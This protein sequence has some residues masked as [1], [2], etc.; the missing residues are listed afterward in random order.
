MDAAIKVG[1]QP[2]LTT[3]RLLLR[4]YAAGDLDA[5][6][7][8]FGDPDVTAFTFLGYR[9]REQTAEVL[10]EYMGFLAAHGYGMLA[11]LDRATGE[12]LG[13]AGLFMS[14]MGVPALRYALVKA[15]WGRGYAVEASAAVIDDSFER[16]GLERLIAGVKFENTPSLRVMEKLGFA[17]EETMTAEGHTFGLFSISRE[18][19]RSRKG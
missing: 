16:L 4:P 12:Y 15:A 14:P 9:N 5:M 13:E 19:W 1:P 8:M 18:A 6:A 3:P 2:V 17:Y 11:I 10:E 7:G